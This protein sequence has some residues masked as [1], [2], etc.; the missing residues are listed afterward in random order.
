MDESGGAFGLS[1]SS[2]LPAEMAT[3]RVRVP[4]QG[5]LQDPRH[6]SIHLPNLMQFH[7]FCLEPSALHTIGNVRKIE[8]DHR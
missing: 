4:A 5:D 1:A 2:Q 3:V 6:G 8:S 7:R